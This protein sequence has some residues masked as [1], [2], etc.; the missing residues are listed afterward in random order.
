MIERQ[1]NI[2]EYN[3]KTLY[4]AGKVYLYILFIQELK[5]IRSNI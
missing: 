3:K 1:Y 4:L 2:L 5:Y